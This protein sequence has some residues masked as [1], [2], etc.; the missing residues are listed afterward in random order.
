MLDYVD[1]EENNQ[2]SEIA[3]I[4]ATRNKK[5]V[6]YSKLNARLC[7]VLGNKSLGWIYLVDRML[8]CLSD[9]KFFTSLDLSSGY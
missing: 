2:E 9:S 6:N 1:T 3:N 7:T 5:T 4:S 8:A